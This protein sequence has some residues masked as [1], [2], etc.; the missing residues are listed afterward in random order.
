MAEFVESR[1][2]RRRLPRRKRPADAVL[3]ELKGRDD[4]AQRHPLLSQQLSQLTYLGRKLI[5][6]AIEECGLRVLERVFKDPLEVV[7]GQCARSAEMKN[8][9]LIPI[10]DDVA[11]ALSDGLRNQPQVVEILVRQKVEMAGRQALG[12]LRAVRARP[13]KFR[14]RRPHPLRA[15]IVGSCHH[16]R[17]TEWKHPEVAR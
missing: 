12:T 5:D 14:Y 10:Q 8:I 9:L 3:E 15:F 2:E 17:C 11:P 7:P 6:V 4:F 13:L 1:G 16:A